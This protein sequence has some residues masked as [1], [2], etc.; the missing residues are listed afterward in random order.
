MTNNN[1]SFWTRYRWIVATIAIGAAVVLF[2][3]LSRDS[4]VPVRAETAQR[5]TIRSVVST[6]G[7]VEPLEN[8][9]AHSPVA[10]TVKNLLVKEGDHVRRGQLLAQL[11]DVA[12]RSEAAQAEA[13]IRSS[14]ADLSAI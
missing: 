6:N 2:A 12:A 14:D 10:T 8:F 13:Q 1:A 11:D 4:A 7:K 3:S 5:S 9:E